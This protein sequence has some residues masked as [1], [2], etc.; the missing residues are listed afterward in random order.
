MRKLPSR[1]KIKNKV[2]YEVVHVDEF[3]EKTTVGECRPRNRQIAL[4][5]NQSERQKIKSFI[6][7]I[8]HAVCMER[9]IKIP[10]GSIYELEHAFYYLIFHND[11]D[12]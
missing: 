3:K 6:H 10:H 11:W 9:D 5:I 7:E 4:K 1:V 8:L 12:K 2:E